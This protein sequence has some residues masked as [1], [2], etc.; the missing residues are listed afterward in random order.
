MRVYKTTGLRYRI[1]IV[2][3]GGGL[4]FDWCHV[5]AAGVGNQY[6]CVGVPT[7]IGRHCSRQVLLY[8]KCY[9]KPEVLREYE[10]NR[11]S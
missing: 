7:T 4:H 9:C 1:I 2:S 8:T 10:N 11:S 3:G 5:E 6:N